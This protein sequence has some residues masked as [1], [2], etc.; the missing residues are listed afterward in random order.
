MWFQRSM[1]MLLL[2]FKSH[3]NT[4]ENWLRFVFHFLLWRIE[5]VK[6]NISK[7]RKNHPIMVKKKKKGLKKLT[8]ATGRGG[9]CTPGMARPWRL[10]RLA[11]TILGPLCTGPAKRSARR[12]RPR[13]R[14]LLLPPSAA[15][16]F[17]SMKISFFAFVER[18]R[19]RER[20]W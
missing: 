11:R 14:P 10:A 17:L 13:P 9:T 3:K 8:R 15:L 18:E 1:L 7:P 12:P 4:G 5:S 2:L 19:E 20:E 16:P 6:M